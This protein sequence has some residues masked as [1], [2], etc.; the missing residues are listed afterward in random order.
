MPESVKRE[1]HEAGSIYIGQHPRDQVGSIRPKVGDILA[2]DVVVRCIAQS[3]N[4]GD[5]DS[6]K[7]G[8]R[9]Q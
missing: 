5:H 1:R 4:G 7:E 9:C 8:R 2:A 3:G 6:K